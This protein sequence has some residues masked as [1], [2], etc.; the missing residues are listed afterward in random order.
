MNK[1]KPTTEQVNEM[2]AEVMA[3]KGYIVIGTK[4]GRV[5]YECRQPVYELFG[6]PQE[7]A[8][9]VDCLTDG[10]EYV[11]QMLHFHRIRPDFPWNPE[12]DT[13]IENGQH[14]Y[15]VVETIGARGR[16]S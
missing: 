1:T 5:P 3:E 7:K 6:I 12:K 8:D 9:I 15:R 10:R 2:L 16:E 14:F 13:A 11:E 4:S